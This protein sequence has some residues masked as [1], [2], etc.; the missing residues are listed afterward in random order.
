MSKVLVVDIE[1]TG[2][3][4]KKDLIV[5]IAILELNLKNNST[6]ILFNSIIKEPDFN[7]AHFNSWIFK[8]GY[9]NANELDEAPLL[10]NVFDEIQNHLEKSP[11]TAFNKNFDLGFLRSRGFS[12]PKEFPCIMLVSAKLLYKLKPENGYKWPSLKKAYNFF[13]GK[14]EFSENHRALYDVSREAELLYKLYEA[15][16]FVEMEFSNELEQL[17]QKYAVESLVEVNINREFVHEPKN[18]KEAIFYLNTKFPLHYP[19]SRRIFKDLNCFPLGCGK[20]SIIDFGSG[21]FTFSF[22]FLDELLNNSYKYAGG[23]YDIKIIGIDKSRF[24]LKLGLE[25]MAEFT[26]EIGQKGYKIEYSIKYDN[27]NFDDIANH[28]GDWIRSDPSDYIYLAYS[29]SMSSGISNIKPI[30]NK[31]LELNER[32]KLNIIIIEP[33]KFN[34]GVDIK[35]LIDNYPNLNINEKHFESSCKKPN[36]MISDYQAIY[37]N[38]RTIIIKNC[39]HEI[40]TLLQMSN[41]KDSKQN[42][43]LILNK[44]IRWLYHERLI[45]YLG[46]ALLS[47]DTNQSFSVINSCLPNLKNSRFLTYRI[48]KG[49]IPDKYRDITLINSAYSILSMLILKAISKKLDSHLDTS[50]YSSRICEVERLNRFYEFFTVGYTK[51]SNFELSSKFENKLLCSADIKD[52]FLTINRRLLSEKLKKISHKYSINEGFIPILMNSF[53]EGNGIP[54]GSSLSALIANLYLSQI[55]KS[56]KNYANVFAYGRY[57]DDFKI[58][59][60]P[61]KNDKFKEAF[62]GFIK[63]ELNSL[64]L[65]LNEEKFKINPINKKDFKYKYN[66]DFKRLT[67]KYFNLI[68]PLKY[69]LGLLLHNL[70]IKKVDIKQNYK[71]LVNLISSLLNLNQITF[72]YSALFRYL[73]LINYKLK[74]S[75]FIDEIEKI[76]KTKYIEFE[77]NENIIELDQVSI[78]NGFISQN[79]VW[80]IKCYKFAKKMYDKLFIELSKWDALQE[81]INLLEKDININLKQK[82]KDEKR[83]VLDSDEFIYSLRMIKY[84]VYRLTRLRFYKLYHEENSVLI[85]LLNF[86]R[87]YFP[88]KLIGLILYRYNHFNILKSLLEDS[89]KMLDEENGLI[90]RKIYPNDIAFLWH[91]LGLYYEENIEDLNVDYEYLLEQFDTILLSRPFEEKLAITEFILR[92]NLCNKISY[93][94]WQLWY[95]LS[96]NLVVLKNILICM[97]FHN[98][99]PQNIPNALKE[100]IIKFYNYDECVMNLSMIVWNKIKSNNSNSVINLFETDDL[101]RKIQFFP[102]DIDLDYELKSIF[103]WEDGFGDIFYY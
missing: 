18:K 26:E 56:I 73:V 66:R 20:I 36:G 29:A 74:D 30:I 82:I 80:L 2:L 48:Q 1:T 98:K 71:R 58:I 68:N 7:K 53:G 102:K 37:N 86:I 69:G 42:L 97:A 5:E 4:I 55:D 90:S 72:I 13:I 83:L 24:S 67:N 52:Y 63:D 6:K 17:Y 38:F 21:P 99:S 84:L 23:A 11:V 50:V 88:I 15:G 45:D 39:N 65:T 40:E 78:N 95:K 87:L 79:R 10:D 25:M 32:S 57:M 92:L 14:E 89:M 64:D 19:K 61:I 33:Y 91:L 101:F 103:D 94:R 22:A 28:I 3:D 85:K 41:F 35:D 70:K 43:T 9:V 34:S 100:R 27:G 12:I 47:Y 31:L 16:E 59:I 96:D 62:Q 93:S 81:K 60:N 44:T 54:I 46:I 51:Y 8:E 75:D 77:I 49:L 76:R